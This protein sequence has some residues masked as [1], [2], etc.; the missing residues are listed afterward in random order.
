MLDPEKLNTILTLTQPSSKVGFRWWHYPTR[1]VGLRCGAA[2]V[3]GVTWAR[4]KRCGKVGDATVGVDLGKSSFPI[5]PGKLKAGNWK[6]AVWEGKFIFHFF[7]GSILLFRGCNHMYTFSWVN[8]DTRD[9]VIC[10]QQ[11]DVDCENRSTLIAGSLLNRNRLQL[12]SYLNDNVDWH[13]KATPR[14]VFF[15]APKEVTFPIPQDPLDWYIYLHL[16]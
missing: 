14:E 12:P 10:H 16:P 3:E 13:S 6:S 9:R 8:C 1:R 15:S 7:W 2:F 4:I 5:H 11:K